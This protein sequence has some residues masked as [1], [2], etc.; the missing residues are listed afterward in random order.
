M[1]EATFKNLRAYENMLL[2]LSRFSTRVA[3]TL[4]ALLYELGEATA[5][6]L[7]NA[8]LN[9]QPALIDKKR[10]RSI[11]R[12]WKSEKARR[13]WNLTSLNRTESYAKSIF[14]EHSGGNHKILLPSTPY[15]D[16]EETYNFSFKDLGHWLENGTR[17]FR[18]IKHWAPARSYL[19]AQFR[20]RMKMDVVR[21]LFGR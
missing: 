14:T 15:T 21:A 18:A 19:L 8:I 6:R 1:I 13:G 12:S 2:S 5:A 7:R 9:N 4:D 11:S 10:F 16:G 20:K 3:A 17:R